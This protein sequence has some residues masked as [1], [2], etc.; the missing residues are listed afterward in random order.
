MQIKILNLRHF[1]DQLL[2]EQIVKQ[3]IFKSILCEKKVLGY[4]L[5]SKTEKIVVFNNFKTIF[6]L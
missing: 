6:K 4:F 5:F 3:F 1:S 2:E